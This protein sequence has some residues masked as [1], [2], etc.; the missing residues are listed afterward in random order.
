MRR[1]VEHL[2]IWG[3][4]CPESRRVLTECCYLRTSGRDLITSKLGR[5]PT[6]LV[7]WLSAPPYRQASYDRIRR[8][9]GAIVVG[10]PLRE[11]GPRCLVKALS[12]RPAHSKAA[13]SQSLATMTSV[14]LITA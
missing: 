11:R 5:Q 10:D 3:S 9:G 6:Q 12:D 4:R 8:S 14:A 2:A 13:H 7:F 1:K